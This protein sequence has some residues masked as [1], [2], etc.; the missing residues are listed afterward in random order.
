MGEDLFVRGQ[1]AL[2]AAHGLILLGGLL[3]V[4]SILAGLISRRV[5]APT[6]LVFLLVGML[7]GE[8]GLIGIQFDDFRGAYLV[9]SVALAIILFE[10]GVKMPIPRLRSVFWPA[11]LLATVGVAL[12]AGVLGACI[13]F[14]FGVRLPAGMLVGSAAAPTDAAAVNTMLR[15]A[16]VVLPGR[17]RAL[18]EAESGFNDPMSI[19][20]TVLLLHIIVAPQNLSVGAAILFFV[21]EMAGGAVFGLAGGW[22]LGLALRVLRLDQAV[23]GVLAVAGALTLFSLAQLLGTSGFLATYLAALMVG[24]TRYHAAEHVERFLESL[25]WLAQIVLFLMLGLL[26]TPHDLPRFIPVAV[27]GAIVLI[28]LARPIA[29]MPFMLPLGFTWRESAFASWVGLRGAVPIYISFLPALVDPSRDEAFFAVIFVLVVT[30]LVI[31]G[32]TIGLAGR[33]LGF[34]TRPEGLSLSPRTDAV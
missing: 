18:L 30:S 33:I 13:A 17:L 21:R 31:Q 3:G 24:A 25:S 28:F 10:G 5:G 8:D 12:T 2:H 7:T 4:C 20:L 6:L 16:G 11:L 22:L 9:G 26:V 15:H 23:A 1:I 32:W 19:F 34:G 27:T 14:L 29:V